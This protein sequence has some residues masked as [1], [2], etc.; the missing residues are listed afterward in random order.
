MDFTECC[1]TS[2]GNLFSFLIQVFSQQPSAKRVLND[3][4][5][6]LLVHCLESF[7][8]LCCRLY[9]ARQALMSILHSTLSLKDVTINEV[10]MFLFSFVSLPT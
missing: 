10:E 8:L 1:I 5:Q 2:V 4:E 7:L 3:D 9:P 6:V